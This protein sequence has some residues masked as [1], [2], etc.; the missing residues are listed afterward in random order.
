MWLIVPISSAKLK[1]GYPVGCVPV[2]FLWKEYKQWQLLLSCCF[3][4]SKWHDSS[5]TIIVSHLASWKFIHER[6]YLS[7]CH[8]LSLL[9]QSVS[10]IQKSHCSSCS[11]FVVWQAKLICNAVIMA[12]KLPISY[13]FLLYILYSIFTCHVFVYFKMPKLCS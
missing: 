1:R 6:M 10:I 7:D 11:P 12:L 5:S 2:H 13:G 8:C 9:S 3:V 4:N